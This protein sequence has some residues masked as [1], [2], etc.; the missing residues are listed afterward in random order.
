[1]QFFVLVCFVV[2]KRFQGILSKFMP[3]SL[4]G[5]NYDEMSGGEEEEVDDD[6]IDCST[7]F[8]PPS[9]SSGSCN[10]GVEMQSGLTIGRHENDNDDDNEEDS[11]SLLR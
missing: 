10:E 5:R 9:S 6:D 3:G 4:L 7:S 1:M 8:L 2:S 11:T